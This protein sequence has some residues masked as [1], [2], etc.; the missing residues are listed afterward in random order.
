[1]LGKPL[2]HRPRLLQVTR[3]PANHGGQCPFGSADRSAADRRVEPAQPGRRGSRAKLLRSCWR[4]GR[5]AH[6]NASRPKG[7]SQSLQAEDG[8]F[9]LIGGQNDD[10]GDV[11][12]NRGRLADIFPTVLDMMGLERPAEMAGRSLF[13][14]SMG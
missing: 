13:R 9:S 10:N 12:A 7:L 4:H 1:M 6:H 3:I 5:H 2:D 8:L 14:S 11:R